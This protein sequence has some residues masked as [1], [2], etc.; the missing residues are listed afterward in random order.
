MAAGS[1]VQSG[2]SCHLVQEVA[3]P[4]NAHAAACVQTSIMHITAA[5][6]PTPCQS[7]EN[8]YAFIMP[9]GSS[10]RSFN[11]TPS[12]SLKLK[13]KVKPLPFLFI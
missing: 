13:L 4:S 9:E 2:C 5:H 8:G 3:V 10:R 11:L 12:V 7:K 1:S 6:L